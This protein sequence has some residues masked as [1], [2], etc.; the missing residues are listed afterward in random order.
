MKIVIIAGTNRSGSMSKKIALLLQRQYQAENVETEVIDLAD[1]PSTLFVPTIYGKEKPA[2]FTH[3]H[4]KILS[5]DGLVFVVPEYNGS[6]PGALKFFI[7]LWQYPVAFE[8]KCV[9]FVGLSS[10]Q[11]GALRPI[12]HLQGVFGYRNAWQFNERVFINH[13]WSRWNDADQ[14]LRPLVEKEVD[15]TE[16][17]LSQ[18][19][20]FVQFCSIHSA[21]G[22][23]P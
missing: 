16:L 5:A 18:T 11:W 9:A 4:D 2:E 6:Y 19:K 8:R 14:T 3:F 23:C 21:A 1:L 13:I 7:D 12:E 17:L 22:C 15:Y 20:G 10:N